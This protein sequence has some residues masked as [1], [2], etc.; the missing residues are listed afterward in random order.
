[1]E[2]TF[3]ADVAPFVG[4]MGEAIAA[5]KRFEAAVHDARDAELELGASG[6]EAG[7]GLAAQTAA[8]DAA[9]HSADKLNR[10]HNLL[11]TALTDAERAARDAGFGDSRGLHVGA[12]RR[13][14][15]DD[16]AARSRYHR[17]GST[18]RH[19]AL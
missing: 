1:M 19:R 14:R 15:G 17:P 9:A 13:A 6:A 2:Y 3:S 4:A 16:G 5:A 18:D 11:H 12:L 10:Q 7:A 8:M